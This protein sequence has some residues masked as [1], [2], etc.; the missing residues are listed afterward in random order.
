[1]LTFENSRSVDSM[2]ARISA[3]SLRVGASKV[4]SSCL[5]IASL[6]PYDAEVMWCKNIFVIWRWMDC[7]LAPA[8][9]FSETV[10]RY[11]RAV[12]SL[13]WLPSR[14]RAQK[15]V[16]AEMRRVKKTCAAETSM[17]AITRRTTPANCQIIQSQRW[18]HR[19]SRYNAYVLHSCT[20]HQI[21]VLR[22]QPT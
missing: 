13:S 21:A 5:I 3:T 18:R 9:V 6:R 12:D 11:L 20:S 19:R 8:P 22:M 1:M 14:Q 17:V 7:M 2:R 16:L 4:S 10:A 15:L